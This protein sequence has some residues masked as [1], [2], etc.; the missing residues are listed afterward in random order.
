M[1]LEILKAWLEIHGPWIEK[2]DGTWVDEP[3]L[4]VI[5]A[6]EVMLAAEGRLVT[7]TALP[8]DRED[9][10]PDELR[11][12]YHWDI[13]GCLVNIAAGT[14][15]LQIPSI[16]QLCPAADWIEREIHD[17]YTVEF[18]GREEMVPLVLRPGADPGVFR[19]NGYHQEE[20]R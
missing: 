14:H 12:I 4:N 6:A 5:R 1:S 11:L 19:W 10:S 20:D 18:T 16:A 15:R 17:Y 8:D 2:P 3:G 7:I 13:R 9:R